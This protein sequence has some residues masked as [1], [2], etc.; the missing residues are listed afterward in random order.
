MYSKLLKIYQPAKLFNN[1]KVLAIPRC[2]EYLRGLAVSGS[3]A[4][5]LTSGLVG[6]IAEATPVISPPDPY[7][8]ITVSTCGKSSNISS[9][10]VP[11]PVYRVAT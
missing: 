3:Q 8:H 5:T 11:C 10:I 4:M 7:G 2:M 9:P 1:P 6:F